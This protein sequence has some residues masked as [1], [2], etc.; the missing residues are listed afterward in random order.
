MSCVL[1]AAA[2]T[3]S[4]PLDRLLASGTRAGRRRMS[5]ADGA[6]PLPE[7]T[8]LK[9]HFPI[10]QGVFSRVSGYVYAVD[11]VSF[12]IERGETL[13]LVGESGCGK[14]TVGRAPLTPPAPRA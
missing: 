5:A 3:R 9:K 12:H 2:A 6:A 10:H 13:G 1:P 14:A 8:G 11:G 7:V 4:G